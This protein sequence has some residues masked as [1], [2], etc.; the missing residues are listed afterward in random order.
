[1][2]RGCELTLGRSRTGADSATAD[3]GPADLEPASGLFSDSGESRVDGDDFAIWADAP[4]AVRVI[5]NAG[6]G[7]VFG[8]SDKSGMLISGE[9]TAGVSVVVLELLA[10]LQSVSEGGGSTPPARMRRRQAAAVASSVLDPA[11]FCPVAL[12]GAAH[13]AELWASVDLLAHLWC[14]EDAHRECRG[15][16]GGS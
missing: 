14:G 9:L 4:T 11:E 5:G 16:L 2:G 13:I 12:T 3:A 1:V 10:R 7:S 8:D 6:S 15:R